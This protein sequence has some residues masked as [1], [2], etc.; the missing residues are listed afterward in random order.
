MDHHYRITPALDPRF[1]DGESD[2]DR[3]VWDQ[4]KDSTV[5]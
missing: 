5:K 1:L 4:M 2:E 3:E